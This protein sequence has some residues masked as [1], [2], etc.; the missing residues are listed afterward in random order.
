[1]E[2]LAACLGPALAAGPGLG[3]RLRPSAGA[4][5]PLDLD[6]AAAGQ[7]ALGA[8]RGDDRAGRRGAVERVQVHAGRAVGQQLGRLGGRVGDAELGD[9]ARVVLA[10]AR[11]RGAAPSGMRAPHSAVMP[12]DLARCS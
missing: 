9:R 3:G 8:Q 12:L 4:P 1:M 6:G 11:A 2:A 7:R 10:R 5:E